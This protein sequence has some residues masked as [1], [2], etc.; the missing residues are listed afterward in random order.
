M[1]LYDLQELECGGEPGTA[2]GRAGVDGDSSHSLLLCLPPVS[3]MSI[4][5]CS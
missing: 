2:G 3:A 1:S 4:S 5:V